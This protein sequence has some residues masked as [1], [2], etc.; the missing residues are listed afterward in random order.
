MANRVM[1]ILSLFL[2]L[3]VLVACSDNSDM[4]ETSA[5][6]ERVRQLAQ[7]APDDIETVIK[8][9]EAA[10]AEADKLGFEWSITQP[11]LKE[12]YTEYKA[13]NEEQAKSLFLEVRHQSM[14]AIEQ[15]HYAEKHWQLL[16]PVIE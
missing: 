16:I 1:K 12:A 13:G 15:A 2:S 3:N 11:L 7:P 6:D 5:Q 14:L 9:A 4:S 10:L 8:Q